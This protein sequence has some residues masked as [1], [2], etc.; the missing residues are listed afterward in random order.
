MHL[1]KPYKLFLILNSIFLTF[2]LMAEVIGSKL[3]TFLGFTMTLGVIPFPVTFIIT[4]LLNEYFGRKGVRLTTI[5]GMLMVVFAYF[6]ILIGIAI[7]AM[8]DSPVNDQAFEMVFFNSSLVIIGSITAYVIGQMIDIQVFHYLRIKT[9]G[10][11]IWLRA[12]GSTI[13]SQLVDSF[14]VIF[15]A[16]GQYLALEKLLNISMTN[17]V[18]K[19]GVAILITPLLYLAH[20]WLDTYLGEEA[21]NLKR[22]A[23][24]GKENYGNTIEAG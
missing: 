4:D 10:K 7:P 12:T 8:P 5:I 22:N 14:V 3:F 23:M 11:K 15:I 1:T 6:L 20:N 17:F 2:L 13:I 21:E 24:N 16:F 19:L 9:Q 18:Y